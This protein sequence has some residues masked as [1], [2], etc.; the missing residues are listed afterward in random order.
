MAQHVIMFI[1][2]AVTID[3]S[4]AAENLANIL[5]N[6]KIQTK[7]LPT[8]NFDTVENFLASNQEEDLLVNITKQCEELA[9]N[10]ETILVPGIPLSKPYAKELNFTIAISLGTALIFVAPL[11]QNVVT[12]IKQLKIILNPYHYRY[13]QTILGFIL[14]QDKVI[15][16]KRK[17][18]HIDLPDMQIPF[19]GNFS[20]DA[21]F[22]NIQT[23]LRTPRIQHVTPAIFKYRLIEKACKTHKTIILPEG[24]EPRTIA[25]ANICSERSIARCILLEEKNKIYA[26]CKEFNLK[27]HEQI[28]IIEPHTI[29][30]QYVNP[31]YEIRRAKGLTI[32]EAR[33]QLKDN[34]VLGTMMLHAN[35]VDGLVSGAI[36]TTA[37]TI[38]PA[39]QII[40]TSPDVK[41]VSSIFFMCLPDQV[42]VFGDCA[43]NPE[44][45]PEELADITIQ[46]AK[47]AVAFG[48]DP[49]VAMLSYS[50][51][52]SGNGPN[53]D[54]VRE[55]IDLVKKLQPDLEVEGPIQYD[56]AVSAETAK[57]KAPQSKVA[58][59]ATVFVMPNLD[60]GNIVYKAVQRNTGI[61]C[62]GPMLQGLR[63][64]VN[65]LSRG[66][67]I[68]D[69]VFTIAI[70][71]IQAI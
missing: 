51:G 49:K 33:N 55:A 32:A 1:P 5:N 57:I 64:P 2:T 17:E 39:L 11:E 15:A 68:N 34:V 53:V 25:A 65:D 10:N 30:E 44:P 70:T 14:N 71:A 52:T 59:R 60:V 67:S 16:S 27:L 7:I 58:G 12:T 37:N 41:L 29:V 22:N 62:V 6:K 19:L 31:L 20:C 56:A 48:I 9:I 35:E 4:V 66:C 8:F 54:K 38:R 28:K 47:S 3:T 18:S 69:I 46:S 36:H 42:A 23:F 45:N 50:T 21:A 63:K 24:A 61:I 26:T 40:K 13:K 43:I